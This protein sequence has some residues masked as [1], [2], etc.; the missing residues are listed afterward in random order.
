MQRW[1]GLED[2]PEDWGRSVVTI[3]SYDGVHRGHQLIIR[4][5]VDR[6]RELGVPSVVVTF[7]PHPSEVVRPGSHPPL[8]APH[9]RRAELM[10]ELGVDA[11]L[12]ATAEGAARHGELRTRGLVHRCGLLLV[13]TP[14]GAT[15]FDCVL[16]ELARRV[17]GFAVLV[18]GWLTD[19]P[20]EWAVVVGPS[21]RRMI[22]NLA[23]VGVP[24]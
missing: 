12:R 17:P 4:H 3:G 20:G 13:R 8:L 2:I 6:A 10:A 16:V 5:A 18:A 21:T 24:A 22:E 23:G 9:H 11:L 7:D 15:R 19:T 14:D 1:R